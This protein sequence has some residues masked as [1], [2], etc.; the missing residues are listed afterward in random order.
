MNVYNDIM[1]ILRQQL[2]VPFKKLAGQNFEE[3]GFKLLSLVR[4]SKINKKGG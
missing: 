2:N 3:I 4:S 1:E